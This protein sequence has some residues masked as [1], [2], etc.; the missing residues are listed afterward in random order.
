MDRLTIWHNMKYAPNRKSF[1]NDIKLDIDEI[2]K[3][4]QRVGGDGICSC[5]KKNQEHT[6]S[7]D[8]FRVTETYL[9]ELCTGKLGHT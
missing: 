8:V 7:V 2:N 5:G 6:Y 4:F 3:R 9:L 1:W